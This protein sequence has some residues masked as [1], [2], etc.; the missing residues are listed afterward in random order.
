LKTLNRNRETTI[1]EAL[2]LGEV[3][4]YGEMIV[5]GAFIFAVMFTVMGFTHSDMMGMMG[6]IGLISSVVIGA[7][8]V[9]MLRKRI[10]AL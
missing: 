2:T 10:K 9:L 8:G 1:G 7:V 6:V 5:T 3:P 4:T